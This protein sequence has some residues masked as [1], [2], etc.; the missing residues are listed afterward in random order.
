MILIKRGPFDKMETLEDGRL[1]YASDK[2]D[3]YI[4]SSEGNVKLSYN[5]LIFQSKM[6]QAGT[7]SPA[8]I[9]KYKDSLP[10]AVTW[11]R[12]STGEYRGTLTNAFD[13]DTYVE[14]ID[15]EPL[16]INTVKGGYINDSNI[17]IV[18]RNTSG[19]LVDSIGNFMLKIYK[20]T[21][22]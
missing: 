14:I 3:L 1:Y 6:S 10:G 9:T 22:L 11:S 13:A 12:D 15:L 2:K 5:T 19:T 18:H 7:G 16:S 21:P 20:L 17:Y 4:G 8:E